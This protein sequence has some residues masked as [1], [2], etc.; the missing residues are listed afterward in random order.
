M[1]RKRLHCLIFPAAEA[2]E[3]LWSEP[4]IDANGRE[5]ECIVFIGVELR[6]FAA[7]RSVGCVKTASIMNVTYLTAGDKEM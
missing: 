3:R 4:R 5:C 7:F 2:T 6:A 1:L